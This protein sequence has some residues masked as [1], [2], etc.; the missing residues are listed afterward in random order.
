MIHTMTF[1]LLHFQTWLFTQLPAGW[2]R[3]LQQ[4][5]S[6]A[7]QAALLL[8]Q[9]LAIATT[10]FQSLQCSINQELL[11]LRVFCWLFFFSFPLFFSPQTNLW[12]RTPQ[13]RIALFGCQI[14]LAVGCSQEACIPLPEKLCFSVDLNPQHPSGSQGSKE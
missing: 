4:T 7:V 10:G 8:L 5:W 2:P 6:S 12:E 13:H 9:H 3:C 14:L 1:P 11:F